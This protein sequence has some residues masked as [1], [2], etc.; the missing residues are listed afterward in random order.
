MNFASIRCDGEEE[1]GNDG[2]ELPEEPN[3]R[4]A[5]L[6][7][8]SKRPA[9]TTPGDDEEDESKQ[10][11]QRVPSRPS[12]KVTKKPRKMASTDVED[13][14]TPEV[15][16]AKPR[17]AIMKSSA[18]IKKMP[19]PPEGDDEIENVSKE[20]GDADKKSETSAESG[21]GEHGAEFDDAETTARTIEQSKG[22]A[23]EASAKA[24]KYVVLNREVCV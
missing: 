13:M 6:S 23:K 14:T 12:R 17:K 4:T 7:A 24:S 9:R 10:S 8:S 21:D 15:K 1:T 5:I 20:N 3:K 19:S 11:T 16:P 2:Y 22:I 18:A